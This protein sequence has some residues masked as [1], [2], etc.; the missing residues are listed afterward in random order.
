MM[1][2]DINILKL[3]LENYKN[4]EEIWKILNMLQINILFDN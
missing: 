3:V 4:G 2:I 1:I